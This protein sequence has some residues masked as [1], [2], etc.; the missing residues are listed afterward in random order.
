M[1]FFQTPEYM[2]QFSHWNDILKYYIIFPDIKLWHTHW[3][4]K[5]SYFL[6]K[7]FC[8]RFFPTYH[9]EAKL[10]TYKKWFSITSHR[11]HQKDRGSCHIR[12]GIWSSQTLLWGT[13]SHLK[14]RVQRKLTHKGTEHS[15]V[16]KDRQWD[17]EQLHMVYFGA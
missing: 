6:L 17:K 9:Y 15:W 11:E 10:E 1:Y 8:Y 4:T 16:P 14:C 12:I 3:E 5:A 13:L 2:L 7:I